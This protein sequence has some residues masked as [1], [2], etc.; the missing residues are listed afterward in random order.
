LLKPDI[1]PA[2]LAPTE[3]IPTAVLQ[4]TSVP[5]IAETRES[6]A[7]VQAGASAEVTKGS[8]LSGGQS[9]NE[10]YSNKSDFCLDE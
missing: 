2:A 7:F 4:D 1:N 8:L 5:A 9:L 3:T 10:F 6:M